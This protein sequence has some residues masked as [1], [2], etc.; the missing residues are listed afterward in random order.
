MTLAVY[1]PTGMGSGKRLRQRIL[2]ICA[3]FIATGISLWPAMFNGFPLLYA[4]SMTYVADGSPVA[5]AVF[6]QQTSV[7]YGMRSLLYSLMILPL[8][9]NAS[10]WPVIL[11]QAFLMSYVL[12]LVTRSVAVGR[13]IASYL[14]IVT[15]LSFLTS[16][17]WYTSMV[18]PDILG[19]VLYMCIYL[20]VF[21]R[22]SLSAGEGYVVYFAAWL[23]LIAHVT[24]LMIAMGLVLLLTLVFVVARRGVW[25]RILSLRDTVVL[26]L[27]S[28]A[29]IL[30]LNGILY[31]KPSLDGER[32]PYLMARII[33]DGTGRTYLENHC[34][35]SHWAICED[36]G[37]I[38]KEADDIL[39]EGDGV[40]QGA[41]DSRQQQMLK[42]EIPFVLA[43]I[44]A[45]PLAQFDRSA[46]NFWNQLRMFGVEDLDASS[47]VME[48]FGETLP[49]ERASYINSR[50]HRNLL[51][52]DFITTVQD[53]A[54][55]AAV[56]CISL[57]TPILWK[58]CSSELLWLGV[59]I[60]AIEI[61]NAMI[62]GV[63]SMVDDRYQSRVMWMLLY[64]ALLL[65]FR[66]IHGL[67]LGEL[68]P[69]GTKR[70]IAIR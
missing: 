17:S 55:L 11:V 34:S 44:R 5:K 21:A 62:G 48:Q 18:M 15:A 16:Y 40:W 61:G 65:L 70:D 66:L 50:Q 25:K 6:L 1:K 12:W 13:G 37:S 31:G 57:I 24:H 7:Y 32:P 64:L 26:I 47:W 51:P 67:R 14:V 68:R 53:W 38:P 60:V 22:K 49:L 36:V 10:A 29:S 33:A 58:R 9:W 45:Y 56:A 19:P 2:P 46:A 35:E 4:D 63:L 43:T 23:G 52:L 30:V 69:F 39:W 20:M 41:S 59:V 27:I 8:H 3:V 54:V 28:V 42:E